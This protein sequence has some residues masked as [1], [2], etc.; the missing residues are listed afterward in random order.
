M[1]FLVGSR[2]T[3]SL[4]GLRYKRRI[5]DMLEDCEQS[6]SKR[7]SYCHFGKVAQALPFE[8][9]DVEELDVRWIYSRGRISLYGDGIMT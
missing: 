5:R 2:K 3:I 1:Y 7:G 4:S 6:Y 9:R 8:R